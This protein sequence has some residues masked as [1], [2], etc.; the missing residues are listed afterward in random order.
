MKAT[1]HFEKGIR[2]LLSLLPLTAIGVMYLANDFE[3]AAVFIVVGVTFWLG[4]MRLK[5]E[6]TDTELKY[7]LL[8]W[9]FKE[10][11]IVLTEITK[12]EIIDVVPLSDYL[13]WGIRWNAK[14][15]KGYILQSGKSLFI[16]TKTGQKRV[17]S[18]GRHVALGERV[19]QNLN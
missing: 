7:K 6:L 10:Q 16:E 1:V 17:F 18:L 12:A 11:S 8:G 13:G 2:I 5:L 15:G 3:W 4:S 14:L 19:I 9:H